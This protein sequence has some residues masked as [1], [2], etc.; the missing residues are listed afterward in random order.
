MVS[1]PAH[2]NLDQ[3]RHQARDLLRAAQ[4]GDPEAGEQVR[5]VSD[6]LNLAGAQL[7]VARSYRFSSWPKLKAAVEARTADL[8]AKAAAFCEASVRDPTG[9]AA[10]LLAE[11]PEIAGHS[12]AAAVLL[13]DVGRVRD[14]IERDPGA[15]TRPDPRTGWTPLH[16]VCASR[17]HYFDPDRAAGLVAVAGLLLEAGAD[18]NARIGAQ[19]RPAGS[20]PL[21]CA[22][23][24]ASTGVGHEAIMALLLDYGAVIEDEDLFLAAFSHDDHRCLRLLLD[25]APDV[26]AVAE[27]ALS[28]PISTGDTEGV[29]LLLEAGAD[30]RRFA[31]NGQPASV[32]YAAVD[33]P[34]ELVELLLSHGARPDGP[35]PDGRSPM[36]LA[37]VRGRPDLAEL[38]ARHGARDDTTA[39]E[40]FVAACMRADRAAAEAQVAGDPGLIDRLDETERA[41]LV[42]AAGAGNIAAVA[43]MLD[44][45]IPIGSRSSRDDGATALHVAAWTGSAEVVTLLI[46]RGADLEAPDTT[47]QSSPLGWAIVGSGERPR[48]NPSPDWIA[49]VRTLLDAGASIQAITLSPDDAKPP[50]AEVAQLLRAYGLES[51]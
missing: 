39:S 7:A 1:L 36:A 24:S 2:P 5:A 9:R 19:G 27:L 15:A 51:S 32:V 13:G 45:G 6:R 40:R 35:G 37:S 42:Q 11:T 17:W 43:L 8:A 33:A 14:E 29:R 48:S 10:R 16:A 41:A 46:E 12:L 50:S 25:R 23:A 22:T 28:A 4:R 31:D 20:S 26:V 44:L 21:R 38:L 49:T 30:P 47:F 3:L 34:T 18:P